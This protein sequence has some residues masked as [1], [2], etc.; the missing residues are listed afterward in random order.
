MKLTEILIKPI[1][2]EKINQQTEKLR[3]YAFKVNR[4]AN[5]L[6]IKKA[7]E[8]FY[9]VTVTDVNTLVVPAKNKS[10]FTKAGAINGRKP[11]YKK[12]TVTVA[13]GETIDLYANV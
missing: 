9:G 3:R 4:G 5:K 8:T 11:A 12:A 6:E 10:R 1:L 7:V 13:E 2:T